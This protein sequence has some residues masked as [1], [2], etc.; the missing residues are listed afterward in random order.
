MALTAAASPSSFPQSSSG[1]GWIERILSYS[2]CCGPGRG[3]VMDNAGN[4]YA[5]SASGAYGYGA[6][7]ELMPSGSGWTEKVLYSF[8]GGKRRGISLQRLDPRPVWK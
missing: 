7:F 4:L 2:G 8:Q 3:I 1:G 6:V 5:I